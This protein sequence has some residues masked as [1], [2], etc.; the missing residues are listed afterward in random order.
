MISLNCS[1]VQMN[2]TGH[3]S[4][5]TKLAGV[6]THTTTHQIHKCAPAR[7][8][9]VLR[10]RARHMQLRP[11]TTG[12]CSP[13]AMSKCPPL[14]CC[15]QCYA[16]TT[17]PHHDLPVTAH[18]NESGS[19]KTKQASGALKRSQGRDTHAQVLRPPKRSPITAMRAPQHLLSCT[20]AEL[21]DVMVYPPQRQITRFINVSF[22][23]K[24]ANGPKPQQHN[25]Q[26]I[27]KRHWAETS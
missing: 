13:S 19:S 14:S 22:T 11:F 4:R 18:A 16:T 15:R 10:Q 8:T 6:R 24:L 2:L 3:L 17:T 7:P 9:N 25:S 21:A 1:S 5:Q 26:R 12:R 20:N 27:V 23:P